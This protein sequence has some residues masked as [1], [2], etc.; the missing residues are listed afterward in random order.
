MK[1]R[2]DET[3]I[4]GHCH[5]GSR[6]ADLVICVAWGR[7]A[8]FSGKDATIMTEVRTIVSICKETAR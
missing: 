8:W 4:S 3:E 2:S 5:A 6:T 1:S 7:E